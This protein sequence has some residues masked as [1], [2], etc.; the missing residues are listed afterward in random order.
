MTTTSSGLRH[1]PAEFSIQARRSPYWRE[2][3]PARQ[4]TAAQPAALDWSVIEDGLSV[5]LPDD[6]KRLAEFYPSFVLDDFAR[7]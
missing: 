4:I 1:R 6:F 7:N 3:F 2:P 5:T